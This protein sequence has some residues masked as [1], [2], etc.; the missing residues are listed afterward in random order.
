ML[1]QRTMV[2]KEVKMLN[3][4]G[5]PC[6]SSSKA[7]DEDDI[8]KSAAY[9]ECMFRFVED[10]VG[11]RSP[12]TLVANAPSNS[13][14]SSRLPLCNSSTQFQ[15]FINETKSVLA[16]SPKQV[17]EEIGCSVRCE[18]VEFSSVDVSR[19]AKEDAESGVRGLPSA[20][21]SASKFKN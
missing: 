20:Q 1:L 21:K 12:W 18:R 7:E 13:N 19:I 8:E 6:S 3:R 16:F 11:C 4:K 9:D 10:K 14:S 2:M 5:H 15:Q 17:F